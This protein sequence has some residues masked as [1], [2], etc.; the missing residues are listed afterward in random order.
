[1][2]LSGKKHKRKTEALRKLFLATYPDKSRFADSFRNLRINIHFSFM[3][4]ELKSLL[5]TS[6]GQEEG[7]TATSANLAY[8]ISRAGKKV[9]MIDA[10]M[11]KPSLSHMIHSENS[12]G[13][14]GLLYDT[15]GTDV[16][17]G[18]L[19]EFGASDLLWLLLFQKRTGCLNLTEGDEKINIY[20]LQGEL[21]DIQWLT[22]PE[23]KKLATLLLKNNVVTQE[24]IEQALIR[25]ENTGQKLAFI[26]INMGFVKEEDLSGFINL[27]MIEGLRNA[28]QFKSGKFSFNKL[29]DSHFARP[30]FE[31]SNF[32]KLYRQV[33]IGEEE[34]F[35]LQK[36]IDSNIIKTN[37]ENLF[38]LPSGH[39]P[40][41]PAELLGSRRMSFLL[42][43]FK[44]RFDV[45]IIDSPSILPASDA[46]LLAPQMDGVVLIVKAGMTNR[47]LVKK[48]VEKLQMAKANLIGVVLN[49]VDFKREGYYQYYSKY[50]GEKE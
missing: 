45:L 17:S 13:L 23:E 38:F 16:R 42:S 47:E 8:T 39:I 24:Q 26:L 46:L 22:R 36:E 27:H 1:V 5:I 25:K 41:N 32:K 44:K 4:K 49:Q 19:S 3:D 30:S 6:S 7:K 31:P 50:Y 40:P 21:V 37:V 12:L 29:N 33:L 28:L 10:D 15:L 2:A 34:F 20:F 18:S 11:R 14:S 48:T 43:F 9:L 35:Y